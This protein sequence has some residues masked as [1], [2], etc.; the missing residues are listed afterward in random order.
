MLSD[1]DNRNSN[2]QIDPLMNLA[3][4]NG[5]RIFILGCGSN[6]WNDWILESFHSKKCDN[7]FVISLCPNQYHGNE[8]YEG[9]L[10]HE[11]NYIFESMFILI[12]PFYH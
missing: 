12:M 3:I 11:K 8:I 7:C 9:K 4:D 5:L 10:G 2:N 6:E 1:S